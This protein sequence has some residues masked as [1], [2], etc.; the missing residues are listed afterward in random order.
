MPSNI[1]SYY[2]KNDGNLWVQT[3]DRVHR[4]ATTSERTFIWRRNPRITLQIG[5][6]RGG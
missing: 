3:M 4:K 5:D 2:V 1:A 6:R